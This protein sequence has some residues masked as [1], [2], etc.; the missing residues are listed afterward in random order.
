MCA[1]ITYAVIAPIILFWATIGLGLF[2][3]AYR[4]NILFVTDSKIDTKGLI[5]PR[6]LKQLTAGVYLAEACMVGMFAVSKAAGPAVLMVVFLVFTF[7]FHRTFAKA[8]DP[9]L[10]NLPRTLGIEEELIQAREAGVPVIGH[11]NGA[12]DVGHTNGTNG[13]TNGTNGTNGT[14]NGVTKNGTGVQKK[15]N[16]F[17]KFL[18]PWQFANYETL[19]HL[20]PHENEVNIPFQYDDDM[21]AKAYYPPSV[22]SATPILWIPEDP[23]GVSKQEIALTSKVIPIS[24]EGCTLDEKNKLNWDTEGARPPIWDEKVHY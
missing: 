23:L 13:A 20:A 11:T 21:E 18:K 7:L 6:A 5:Y 22:T 17:V 14:S 10:Y 4:Y 9:L 24:D 2:Y 12:E 8:L 16:L 15:G 19:R 1:G 3:L